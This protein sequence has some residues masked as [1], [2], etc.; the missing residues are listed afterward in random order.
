MPELTL[1]DVHQELTA[2]DRKERLLESRLGFYDRVAS[3]SFCGLWE[4]DI[5]RNRMNFIG[6]IGKP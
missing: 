6:I 1:S 4:W 3:G 2:A 5:V